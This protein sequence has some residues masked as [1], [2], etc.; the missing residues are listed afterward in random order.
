M[1][2]QRAGASHACLYLVK[3]QQQV[4][5]VAQRAQGFQEG[6]LGFDHAGLALDGLQHHGHG[7]RADEGAHAVQVVEPGF[8]E[9]RHLRRKQAVKAGLAAG[10]HGG[11]GAAVEGVLEGDDFKG[12]A[13]V[14]L[15]ELA[16]Q[17]DGTF[18]G[19][20]ATA[21]EEDPVQAAQR[22]QA[23]GQFRR[24]VVE[25]ARAGLQQALAL[26]GQCGADLRRRVA[27]GVDGPA[28]HQ[29][30]VAAALAVPQ[31]AAVAAREHGFGA[32]RDVHQR[33]GGGW[34]GG[35]I[36]RRHQRLLQGGVAEGLEKAH[37]WRKH[38]L[39]RQR[40]RGESRGLHRGER[41]RLKATWALRNLQ[42]ET[43]GESSQGA[44]LVHDSEHSAMPGH[45]RWPPSRA[46][47]TTHGCGK[48]LAKAQGLVAWQ[49]LAVR[50]AAALEPPSLA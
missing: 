3:D 6:R 34:G 4:L 30:Q 13:P 9:A 33:G 48:Q 41:L 31:P 28:L 5:F 39:K 49:Y 32:A 1:T 37:R 47:D 2:P 50:T 15:A 35:Q 21:G 16:R 43:S 29:V 27:Q 46:V 40:P 19:L 36:Q 22:R 44:G 23:R 38:V 24:A 7:L 10:A 26:G 20:R 25:Q 42:T 17:L 11:Q 8:R 12:A 45:P 18:I 14:H